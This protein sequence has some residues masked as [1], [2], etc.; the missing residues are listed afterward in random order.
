MRRGAGEGADS[1]DPSSLTFSPLFTWICARGEEYDTLDL[2]AADAI[3]GSVFTVRELSHAAS[4]SASCID[5]LMSGSTRLSS[6]ARVSSS[7]EHGATGRISG[8]ASPA[9][10]GSDTLAWLSLVAETGGCS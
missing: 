1:R 7:E 5:T 3:K 4:P 2:E 8:D 9:P 10:R 6:A